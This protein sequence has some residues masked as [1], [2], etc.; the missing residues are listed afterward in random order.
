MP[1]PLIVF[2]DKTHTDLHG[3]LAV[4]PIIFTLSLFN[5][6]ARNN[7]RFWQPLAYIPNLLHGKGK[8]NKTT[9]IVELQ[10]EQECLVLVFKSLTDLHQCRRGITMQVRGRFVRGRA[11]IHFFI[12]DTAG[13][14]TWLGH[15]NYNGSSK[16]KRPY[17]DCL[18]TFRMMEAPNPHFTYITLDDTRAAKKRKMNTRTEKEKKRS[19]N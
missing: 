17:R 7:P 8:K 2:G 16:L 12:G 9:S 6:A 1:V 5:R 10:D 19:T 18:C 15:Y 11:W 4:T 14:N 3:S 13:N